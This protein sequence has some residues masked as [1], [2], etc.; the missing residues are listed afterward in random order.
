MTF[1]TM[2]PR[3]KSTQPGQCLPSACRSAIGWGLV[4][5]ECEVF[6]P[7]GGTIAVLRDV[8]ALAEAGEIRVDVELFPFAETAATY[9]KFARGELR[10]RAVITPN[11]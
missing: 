10:T 9:A 2:V 6:I 11:A 4:P 5:L 3:G 7:Q 8:I 1:A